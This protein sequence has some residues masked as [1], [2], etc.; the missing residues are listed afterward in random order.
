MP[1]PGRL[2]WPVSGV[3][4]AVLLAAFLINAARWHYAGIDDRMGYLVFPR[5][6]VMQGCIGRDVFNFRRLEVGLGGGGAYFYALFQALLGT[7]QTRLASL[8]LGSLCLM[9]LVRGHAREAG[10]SAHEQAS[11]LL[12]ALAVI[13]FSP[14]VN[15]TPET[16]GKAE[17]YALMRVVISTFPD[18]TGARRGVLVGLLVA[19]LALLKTSYLP[20]AVAVAAALYVPLLLT[21]AVGPV[22]IEWACAVAGV[23]RAAA[24]VD[25]GVVWHC[26]HVL[27]SGAWRR[28]DGHGGGHR[29]CRGAAIPA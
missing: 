16:L 7:G 19:C 4:V 1:R 12:A 22:L 8:G 13:V 28:N 9:L 20:P 10:L 23:C 29:L 11:V 24:A 25:A 27:V 26:A 18:R 14:I 15:N 17:L 6:I 21:R 3:L 5:R 2:V